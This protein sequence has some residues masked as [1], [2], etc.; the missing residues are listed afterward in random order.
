[1]ADAFQAAMK[2]L[3]IIGHNRDDLI[4][5]SEAIPGNMAGSVTKPAT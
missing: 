3:A 2:K 5:C 1:M 4:D